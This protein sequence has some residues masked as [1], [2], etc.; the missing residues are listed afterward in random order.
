MRSNSAEPAP[1]FLAVPTAKVAQ[2]VWGRST[3]R[4]GF[5]NWQI[6]KPDLSDLILRF[7]SHDVLRWHNPS[8]TWAYTACVWNLAWDIDCCGLWTSSGYSF[9]CCIH[10]CLMGVIPTNSR[11]KMWI[12]FWQHI[13]KAINK[14]PRLQ[15][16]QCWECIVTKPIHQC[17]AVHRSSWKEPAD[18]LLHQV[19]TCCR[20]G[21][22][23]FVLFTKQLETNIQ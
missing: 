6:L 10:C 12:G 11:H 4:G 14:K 23:L 5:A 7:L 20:L 13:A 18:A 2:T 8:P 9:R 17:N 15:C 1:S 16:S 21:N 22:L 19:G 3:F